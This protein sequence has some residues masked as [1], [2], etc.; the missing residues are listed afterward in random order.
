MEDAVKAM[1]K[2]E[3]L[4]NCYCD[5]V[6]QH[7]LH[8]PPEMTLLTRHIL[9]EYI[10]IDTLDCEDVLAKLI[11]FHVRLHVHKLDVAKVARLL[12]PISKLESKG[13]PLKPVPTTTFAQTS[14]VSAEYTLG[15]KMLPNISF[16][17]VAK[18]FEA[19]SEASSTTN[20]VKLTQWHR[21]YLGIVSLLFQY[22]S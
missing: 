19:F 11:S 6:A 15:Q 13:L 16:F 14:F 3:S 7:K 20:T 1:Q 5:D 22:F 9:H 21:S 18:L 10:D 17:I 12:E 4:W 8:L 2:D